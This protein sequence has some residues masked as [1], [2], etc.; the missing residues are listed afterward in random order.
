MFL[1]I[2]RAKNYEYIKLVE[3]YREEGKSKQRV[4]YNFGRADL[5]RND[6]GFLRIVKQLCEIANL[7]VEHG[8]KENP[9]ADCSEA[10]FY[11][12]GYLAYRKLW[13]KLG[14]EG[15][16]EEAE[17]ETKIEYSLPETTFLMVLQHLLEP[18]S[19]YATCENQE[20]Y[21][22]LP[23]KSLHQMYRA[24][25]RLSEQKEE[26]EANLFEY[27]YVR[28]NKSVDV[29]FY[30]VTTVHFESVY[31]DE[32][33][34]FGFS[35]AGKY[36]EVQVVLGMI[37]DSDGL[38]VGY[39][40]FKGNT[41]E[42]KT[43]LKT[44]EKIKNR[45]RISRVIIVADRGI[46]QKINLKHIKDAGYGYIM[47]AKIKGAS[48]KLQEKIFNEEGFSDICDTEGNLR[49]RYKVMEHE[50]IFKDENKVTHCL[51]ENMIVSYSPKRAKK[52]EADRARLVAKAERLLENPE[53]IKSTN[54]R[55]GRKYINQTSQNTET[56][57][58]ATAKIEQDARFDGFY[59]IQ[60]SEK[61]MSA[62]EIMDA[63]HTLWKIEESFKI[64]KSTLEIRPVY[65]SKPCQIEGHFVVCFLAFLME[66]KMEIILK[67]S[68]ANDD[69]ESASVAKIQ[70]A[71]NS[72]QLAAVTT[73]QGEVFIKSKTHPLASK[74]FSRLKL[75]MPENISYRDDLI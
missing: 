12:Y 33:R 38:P 59:A 75:K 27:N 65:H 39:E 66:R 5:I 58:L 13:R 4:L 74:I 1:K 50:N 64:M 3:A 47:A 2:T 45:F 68:I 23:E 7:P 10:T 24:L 35:K 26:I 11:N 46:N 41:F 37:I 28:T 18:M 31:A 19:K 21:F 22:H 60:T 63:Y 55:G 71:L 29:V 14:I 48:A 43:L 51:L 25:T 67:N 6:E 54:K 62:P 32:L 34:D 9:F 56:Y 17:H 49:L 30:D 70:K 72:M 61:N 40:L 20:R 53:Q 42:G 16:L 44:L 15:C 52:D 8:G 57:E 36:N 69:S 73:K